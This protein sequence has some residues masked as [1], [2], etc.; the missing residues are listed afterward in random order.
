MARDFTIKKRLIL[1]ALGLLVAVDA[2][3]IGYS[4]H[5]ATVSGAPQQTLAAATLELKLLK[6]DVERAQNIRKE[7]P[8]IQEDCDRFEKAMP[9]VTTGYSTVVAELGEIARKAGVQIAG[10]AFHASQ[11]QDKPLSQVDLDLSIDG[12]YSDVVRFLNGV[13][14]TRGLYILNELSLGAGSQY[15]GSSLRVNLRMQTYFRTSV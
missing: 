6:A 12:K 1:G 9:P 11:L 14:K 4:L 2:T 10:V 13:Q 3:L 5:S 7:M 8:A 15:A